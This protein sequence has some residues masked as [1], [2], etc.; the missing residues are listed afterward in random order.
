MG[1]NE[2]STL[3]LVLLPSGLMGSPE[4]LPSF[5]HDSDSEISVMLLH[6]VSEA[7]QKAPVLYNG[8]ITPAALFSK[9][10]LPYFRH[11]EDLL[12]EACNARRRS[13]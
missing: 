8:P 2:H 10:F 6:C 9:R 4:I 7:D 11:S 5:S 12:I 1:T 3:I 13:Q